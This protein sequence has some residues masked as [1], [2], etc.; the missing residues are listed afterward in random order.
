LPRPKITSVTT[1]VVDFS[2]RYAVKLDTWL[3][4]RALK[5][6][7]DSQNLQ[8]L[9][10][11]KQYLVLSNHRSWFD[12][13]ILQALI[14]SNGRLLKFLIKREL[15]YVPVVGWIYLAL[16]FPRLHRGKKKDGKQED[17]RF[18]KKTRD[19]TLHTNIY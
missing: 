12:I 8:P 9:Q 2:Y 7:I 18:V 14:V 5:I 11:G 16:N 15:I 13:L 6:D 10:N 1:K 3:L 19:K 17:I 4:I